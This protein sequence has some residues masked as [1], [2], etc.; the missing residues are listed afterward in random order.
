M[1]DVTLRV[2]RV[3][4]ILGARLSG[5]VAA[6]FGAAADLLA[7]KFMTA[8]RGS[9]EPLLVCFALVTLA[10]LFALMVL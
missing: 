5:L 6:H 2:L 8:A 4:R 10:V 7:A 3:L 1:A 9:A